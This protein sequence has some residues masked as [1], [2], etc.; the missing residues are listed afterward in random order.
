MPL[1][2]VTAAASSVPRRKFSVPT[3]LEFTASARSPA[4]VADIHDTAAAEIQDSVDAAHG[5]RSAGPC[6]AGDRRRSIKARLPYLAVCGGDGSAGHRECGGVAELANNKDAGVSPGAA[7]KRTGGFHRR[8]AI[9]NQA[10]AEVKHC[11][12]E[13]KLAGGNP[14]A[15]QDIDCATGLGIRAWIGN[16]AAVDRE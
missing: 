1:P 16:I 2:L 11:A 6:A 14:H 7:G 5:H 8:A 9:G 3:S 12:V 13:I 10:A 15:A 4:A